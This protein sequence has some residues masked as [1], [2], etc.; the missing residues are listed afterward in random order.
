[1]ATHHISQKSLC[2]CTALRKAT[3]RVSQLYDSALE[4]CGLRSTQRTILIQI[5]RSGTPPLGEL[6]EAL[7]MDRGALTHNLKPL[8]RDGFVKISVDPQDRRNRLVALT[9]Q[10]RAKLAESEVLWARAQRGFEAGF[11]AAK[12]AS[13]RKA[14]EFLVSDDFVNAF[15][16]QG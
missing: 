7:V 15:N 5:A 12:S 14:L 11:G 4:P 2:N 10:G 3:R 1:M 9:A 16:G 8:Q 6:A 13:L